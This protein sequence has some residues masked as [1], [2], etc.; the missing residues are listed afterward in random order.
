M[1][2][3]A[4]TDL[5]DLCAPPKLVAIRGEQFTVPGAP[6]LQWQWTFDA[7]IEAAIEGEGRKVD[8]EQL[9][10]HLVALFTIVDPAQETAARQ[11]L[12]TLDAQ[13]LLLAVRGIYNP[14]AAEVPP[15]KPKTTRAKAA[16]TRSTSRARSR[17]RSR[18]ST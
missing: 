11:G 9:R 18:S 7:L 13:A 12:G 8:L 16:G 6:T 2:T 17:S 10:E 3:Q 14:V 4:L 5:A 15:T 1:S